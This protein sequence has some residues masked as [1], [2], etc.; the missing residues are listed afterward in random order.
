MSGSGT[1]A[2]RTHAA[3]GRAEW[4]PADLGGGGGSRAGPSA[5][6]VCGA[7]FSLTEAGTVWPRSGWSGCTLGP[8]GPEGNGV[9]RPLD[10]ATLPISLVV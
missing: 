8:F 6:K 4:T 5:I 9:P 10:R 3:H 7:L 2:D 1:D